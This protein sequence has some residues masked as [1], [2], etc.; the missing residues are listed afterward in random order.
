[1]A[2][3]TRCRLHGGHQAAYAAARRELGPSVISLRSPISVVR[4]GLATI[5]ATEA[6]PIGVPWTQ[7]I[8]ERGRIIEDTRNLRSGL[9]LTK[10]N[11]PERE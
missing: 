4:R 11:R 10:P 1:M 2:G 6:Y 3:A 8:I 5:A 9:A 7:N